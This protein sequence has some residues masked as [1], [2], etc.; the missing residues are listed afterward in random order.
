MSPP[1]TVFKMLTANLSKFHCTCQE[2]IICGEFHFWRKVILMMI[3]GDGATILQ[4]VDHNFST[5][6][7]KLQYTYPK[8]NN[9]INMFNTETKKSWNLYFERH[10]SIF[11]EGLSKMVSEQIYTCPDKNFEEKNSKKSFLNVN[12]FGLWTIFF[13]ILVNFFQQ[14]WQRWIVNIEGTKSRREKFFKKTAKLILFDLWGKKMWTLDDKNLGMFT[15]TAL[16]VNRETLGRR[17]DQKEKFACLT[18]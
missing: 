9:E 14:G 4:P 3:F 18:I 13:K 5:G 11:N 7:S 1:D 17:Q 8:E 2:N 6:L 15:R 16:L 10:R 12:F